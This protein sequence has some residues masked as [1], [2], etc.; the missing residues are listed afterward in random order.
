MFL[1][2]EKSAQSTKKQNLVG[3]LLVP[4]DSSKPFS[5]HHICD[6]PLCKPF[7]KGIFF[8]LLQNAVEKKADTFL[9]ANRI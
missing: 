8:A 9:F 7:A 2:V 6:S 5:P 4:A 1:K 3:L